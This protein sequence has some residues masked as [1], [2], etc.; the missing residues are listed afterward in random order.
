MT[1]IEKVLPTLTEQIICKKEKKR[2]MCFRVRKLCYMRGV[3]V[4]GATDRREDSVTWGA[5]E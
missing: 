2:N 4:G 3:G 1:L 5:N